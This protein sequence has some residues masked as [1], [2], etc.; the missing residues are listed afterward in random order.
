MGLRPVLT[1]LSLVLSDLD[2]ELIF[3]D[4]Q[5]HSDL[6][7]HLVLTFKLLDFDLL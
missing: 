7:F 5:T 1:Q 4:F 3:T 6:G 2:L